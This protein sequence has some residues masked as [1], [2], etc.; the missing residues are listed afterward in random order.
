[1]K[2]VHLRPSKGILRRAKI[3]IVERPIKNTKSKMVTGRIKSDSRVKS[4][5]GWYHRLGTYGGKQSWTPVGI[6]YFGELDVVN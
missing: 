6:G 5:T 3:T 2:L 4:R 1:M